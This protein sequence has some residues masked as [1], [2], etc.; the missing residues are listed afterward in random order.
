MHDPAGIHRPIHVI[1][2]KAVSF[3]RFPPALDQLERKPKGN[4]GETTHF[5]RG[6]DNSDMKNKKAQ[7]S[8]PPRTSKSHPP[9][10]VKALRGVHNPPFKGSM[11]GMLQRETTKKA[12]HVRGPIR[13]DAYVQTLVARFFLGLPD[14]SRAQ[15]QGSSFK[16]GRRR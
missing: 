9:G 13:K 14:L 8:R 5:E 1:C 10:R 11:F 15:G 3:C 4:Q 2:R 16:T 6:G 12:K 7:N